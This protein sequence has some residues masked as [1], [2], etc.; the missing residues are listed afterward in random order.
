MITYKKEKE[1]ESYKGLVASF[2]LLTIN[3]TK[4]TMHKF[5]I[6]IP[7]HSSP[8]IRLWS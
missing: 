1:K 8:S 7:K 4:P 2:T 5:P 3:A 6:P